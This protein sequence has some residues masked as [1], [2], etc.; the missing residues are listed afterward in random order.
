MRW[1]DRAAC[2]GEDPT[3]FFPERGSNGLAAKR[4]CATCNVRDE[5]LTECLK[6]GL[7]G[8]YGIW[9]GLSERERNGKRRRA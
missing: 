1:Q 7:W 4:I 9:G 5:C 6:L 3:V 2:R 8:R